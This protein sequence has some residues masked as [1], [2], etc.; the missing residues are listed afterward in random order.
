MAASALPHSLNNL[1]HH[2]RQDEQESLLRFKSVASMNG[3]SLTTGLLHTPSATGLVSFVTPLLILGAIPPQ[4]GRF[5]HL[6]ELSLDN[7]YLTGDIP[8]Q[9]GQLSYLRQLWL[10]TNQLQGTIP[11]ALSACRS[12]YDLELSSNQLHGSI[13]PELSLL[14]SLKYLSLAFN[15]ITGT[16]P[17]SLGNISTLV[18]LE[19]GGNNLSGTIPSYLG[20]LS[21]LDYLSLAEN[22]LQG[23]IPWE[24]CTKLS[25]LVKL[26]TFDALESLKKPSMGDEAASNLIAT[27]PEL[28]DNTNSTGTLASDSQSTTSRGCG[29]HARDHNGRLVS[30]VALPLGT[31]T[32]HFAEENVAYIGLQLAICG[33]KTIDPLNS[34][35][36]LV[37]KSS[38]KNLEVNTLDSEVKTATGPSTKNQS[39]N[40]ERNNSTFIMEELEDINKNIIQKNIE[41]MKALG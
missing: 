13:P 16:I 11:P 34:V 7:N 38:K 30:I 35:L 29:G 33:G 20:N 37:A 40:Q 25:K 14:T 5:P 18:Q 32:N 36:P 6:R 8:P 3:N 39:K 41:L 28:L 10:Y 1:S 31:Q 24:I 15:G 17:S 4:V 9:F 23:P 2:H 26:R 19:L 21:N 27:I 12:L 22:H